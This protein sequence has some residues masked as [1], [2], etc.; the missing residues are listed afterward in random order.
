MARI[1]ESEIERLKPEVSLERELSEALQA[2][3]ENEDV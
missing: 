2:G 1:T 3:E